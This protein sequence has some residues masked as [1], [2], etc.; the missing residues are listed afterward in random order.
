MS[1][2]EHLGAS[3]TAHARQRKAWGTLDYC[4]SERG[5]S[6]V[7]STGDERPAGTLEPASDRG[8]G[9]SP[10][11]GTRHWISLAT[12]SGNLSSSGTNS[13]ISFPATALGL[14]PVGKDATDVGWCEIHVGAMPP[15]SR[16]WS[17]QNL[18]NLTESLPIPE[19]QDDF[20]YRLLRQRRS[21][22]RRSCRRQPSPARSLSIHRP[23]F[24]RRRWVAHPATQPGSPLPRLRSD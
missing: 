2:P 4:I 10:P 12:T 7:R 18:R 22:P 15:G 13:M 16:Y 1:S 11:T 23:Q 8:S 24:A 17:G 19:P 20:R 14:L 5:K 3:V 6:T 9:C 21:S